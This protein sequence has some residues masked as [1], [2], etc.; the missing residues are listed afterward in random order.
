MVD[1]H[2]LAH[3]FLVLSGRVADIVA[4]LG[5]TGVSGVGVD[6]LGLFKRFERFICY[7]EKR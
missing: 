5:T 6:L 3:G 4:R 7:A 2:G 1:D